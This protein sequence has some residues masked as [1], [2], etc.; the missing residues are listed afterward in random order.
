M[1]DERGEPRVPGSVELLKH[2]RPLD[3]GPGVAGRAASAAGSESAV[4]GEAQAGQG[5][6]PVDPGFAFGVIEPGS[7]DARPFPGAVPAAG[8]HAGPAPGG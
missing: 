4:E 8:D 5:G 6:E 7:D 3:G 1:T 2:R